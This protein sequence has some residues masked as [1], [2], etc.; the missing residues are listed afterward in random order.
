MYLQFN[1][2]RNATFSTTQRRILTSWNNPFWILMHTFT[3]RYLRISPFFYGLC[4]WNVCC[5]CF[6]RIILLGYWLVE[7]KCCCLFKVRKKWLENFIHIKCFYPL[8]MFKLRLI[9]W[10]GIN[11]P[12]NRPQRGVGYFFSLTIINESLL[13]FLSACPWCMKRR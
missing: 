7:L 3:G 12:K 8:F 2:T 5:R 6:P 9:C 11:F 4:S 1:F 10:I 13:L